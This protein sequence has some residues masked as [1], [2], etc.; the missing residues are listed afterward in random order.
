VKV[1]VN[2]K[3][4]VDWSEHAE[5]L[6][7]WGKDAV[8]QEARK[9]LADGRGAVL[10]IGCGTGAAIQFLSDLP[11][12]ALHGC[13]MSP[14]LINKCRDRG[15]PESRLKVCD[16][17]MLGVYPRDSFDYTF[18]IGVLHYVKE[19]DLRTFASDLARITRR[20]SFHFVPTSL[21]L[22]NEGWIAD[23]HAFQNNSTGWW[24][25]IFQKGFP[26]VQTRDSVWSNK[27]WSAGQ[28]FVCFKSGESPKL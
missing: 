25:E 19:S 6:D 4:S 28:W 9:L 22:K 12:L 21:S 11:G 8:W 13:D 26:S 16:L 24:L 5:L 10:D 1:K 17:K 15:I 18:T 14:S 20:M 3:P 2:A 27:P 7:Q 23:W